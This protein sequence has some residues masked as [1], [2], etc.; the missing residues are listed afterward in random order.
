MNQP[1]RG[2]RVFQGVNGIVL[3]GVVVLTLYP[4]LNIVARSFS[5]ERAIR[6]GEVTLWPKGFDL[7]TYRIVINDSTFWRSYG[8]TVLYTVTATVVAMVLTTCYAYVLSKKN[9]KGRGLLV[10]IAVFTMF[11]SGGLIPNY[12]L[13]TSLGLKN[14]VWAIA[15]P[16]AISVFNLLV[17]KA[18]FESLPSELEEA[19]QIDG[20]STYGILLR[21]VLPLSKAVVATM[22]LFY[23]VSFWNSWFQAFL[24]MDRTDLMP[25]TVYLRNIIAGAT[26]ASNAGATTEQG[27]QVA[28]SIQAVTIVLTSLPILCV[29]PFVQRYFVSGVMLGAVKG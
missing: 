9:L 22:I 25:V 10:G 21:V 6:S 1:T 3:T 15:L 2:Y 11:F 19:A 18:F 29:Y 14:S 8:N 12:V 13:I 28:A 26:G 4:F 5:G 27:T 16:N 23:S 17:M 20:L 24:Y 7:T